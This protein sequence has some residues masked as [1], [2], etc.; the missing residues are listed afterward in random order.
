MPITSHPHAARAV[1]AR[2]PNI[3]W[4][5]ARRSGHDDCWGGINHRCRSGINDRRGCGH[6][7]CRCGSTG[8]YSYYGNRRSGKI[9]REIYACVGR[10][11]GRADKCGSDD[12]QFSFHKILFLCFLEGLRLL[13]LLPSLTYTGLLTASCKENDFLFIRFFGL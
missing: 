3:I 2:R 11:A 1:I 12:E 13:P 5:R 7:Y 4:S 9:N 10:Q 8:G 6:D